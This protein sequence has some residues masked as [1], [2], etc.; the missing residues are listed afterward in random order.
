MPEPSTTESLQ[1]TASIER[2]EQEPGSPINL[3]TGEFPLTLAT[4]GESAD[5]HILHIAGARFAERLPL[6]IDHANSALGTLGSIY[7]IRATLRGKLPVLRG[8]G[9]I[10]LAGEGDQATIRRDLALMIARGHVRSVS[11]R[12]RGEKVIPR[13]ELPTGHFAYIRP[14]DRS[15]KRF[16]MF[17]ETSSIEEGSIVAFGA[18]KRAIIGRSLE[19]PVSEFWNS[20]LGDIQTEATSPEEKPPRDFSQVLDVR[21]LESFL[22]DAGASRSEAKRIIALCRSEGPPREAEGNRTTPEPMLCVRDV[23]QLISDELVGLRAEI[24]R[25]CSDLLRSALGKIH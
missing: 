12:A 18:D 17:F 25:E 24:F 9:R 13:A 6:Q 5:G 8:V 19:A 20:F 14:E 2:A 16:G 21:S 3:E 23:Q 11:V 15:V 10:E 22:R 1:L 7:S 4:Q